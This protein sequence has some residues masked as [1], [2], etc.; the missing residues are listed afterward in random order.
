MIGLRC[1][2]TG[3]IKFKTILFYAARVKFLWLLCITAAVND[4]M[5][6]MRG[7]RGLEQWQVYIY[8]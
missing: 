5:R 4:G 7:M 6:G 1:D 8:I 2:I 3:T